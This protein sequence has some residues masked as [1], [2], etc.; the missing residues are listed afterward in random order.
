MADA[1]KANYH[2]IYHSIDPSK[3][4]DKLKGR[5]VLITGK[6]IRQHQIA[7]TEDKEKVLV[8]A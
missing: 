8:E 6:L 5:V 3:F 2:D 7:K 4:V 1:L